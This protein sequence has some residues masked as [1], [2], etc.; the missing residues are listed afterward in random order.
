MAPHQKIALVNPG[1]QKRFAEYEPLHIGYLAAYL[2]ANNIDVSIIDECAG[3]NLKECL[4]TIKPDIVGVT[5]TTPLIPRAYT[6]LSYAKKEGMRTVIGGPH[7][8]S[9]PDEAK[10]YADFVVVG[11]GERALLKM[12]NGE[13]DSGILTADYINDLDTIPLPARHLIKQEYY[14]DKRRHM[15]VADHYFLAKRGKLASLITSR[16]CPYECIYCHNSRRKTPVRYTGSER[17]IEE[18]VYLKEKYL[19]DSLF[20]MDD[21]FFINTSRLKVLCEMLIDNKIHMEWSANSRVNTVDKETLLLAKEAGLRQVNF[22]IE[23]GSQNVLDFLDK[24]T[25]VE[26][27]EYAV[28]IAREAGLLVYATVMLGNPYETKQDMQAT[29]NFI[30]GNHIDSLGICI[31]TPYPGTELW[32]WCEH[33]NCIPDEYGWGDFDMERCSIVANTILTAKEVELFKT[34]FLFAFLIKSKFRFLRFYLRGLLSHPKTF[35]LKVLH[36]LKFN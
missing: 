2:L 22:G 5:A 6:I 23:S 20:F 8:S 26:K 16:G 29:Q 35:F 21:D 34:R 9:L 1:V 24:K 17:I 36:F 11:E 30:L 7:A 31:T 15:P 28:R 32:E 33:N 19:I 10:K 14:A 3:D 12:V 4:Q 13:A 25:S 18:I 27:A